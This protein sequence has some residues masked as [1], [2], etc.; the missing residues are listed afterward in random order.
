M[1]I[2][3]SALSL[4]LTWALLCLAGRTFNL[5]KFFLMILVGGY[6]ISDCCIDP[7]R[8][9]RQLTVVV[10]RRFAFGNIVARRTTENE[11]KTCE[12]NPIATVIMILVAISSPYL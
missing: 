9:K 3:S 4:V 11:M 1:G 2:L 7:R 12:Q 8:M 10:R 6:L 5:G